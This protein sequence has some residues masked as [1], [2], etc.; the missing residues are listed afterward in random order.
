MKSLMS[1]GG[2][3]GRKYNFGALKVDMSKSY[4]KVRWNFLKAVFTVM[5]FD[6]KWIKWIMECV[7]S[8]H[9]T[10]LVNGNLTNSFTPL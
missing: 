10:L 2:K 7:T 3:K 4:D 5:K 9:Y 1:L 6:S 8:V